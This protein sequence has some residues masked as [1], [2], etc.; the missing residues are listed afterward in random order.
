[1]I[2]HLQQH[3]VVLIVSKNECMLTPVLVAEICVGSIIMNENTKSLKKIIKNVFYGILAI[4]IAAFTNAT[5]K[6]CIQEGPLWFMD[7][8]SNSE[9]SEVDSTLITKAYGKADMLL[10]A[11]NNNRPYEINDVIIKG[12]KYNSENQSYYIEFICKDKKIASDITQ[13]DCE[14]YIYQICHNNNIST[15]IINEINK[16]FRLS[17]IIK[18]ENDETVKSFVL[19]DK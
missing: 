6:M 15:E 14:Q 3:P 10:K 17:F 13:E 2:S 16:L 4:I 12:F 9:N 11:F 8:K 7:N 5:I 19:K 18:D 1:M